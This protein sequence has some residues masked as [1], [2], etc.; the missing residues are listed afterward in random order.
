M[1]KAYASYFGSYLLMNMKTSGNIKNI[2][3]F[4]SVAK[5]EAL[6]ES[7]VDIFI[8]VDKENK[9]LEKEIY[10][11]LENFYKSREALLFKAKNIDNKI[12]LIIG[13]LDE[14]ADLKKSIESTGIILYGRFIPAGVKGRKYALIFWNK[15]EKNRGAFLNKVYGFKVKGKQ[16]K[17]IMENFGGRKLGKSSIMIPIEHRDEFLIISK[18]YGVAA[19]IVEIYA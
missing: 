3:L 17:G 5:N 12:N 10:E 2:I 8:D 13:K 1:L 6:K 4:G 16:Y 14:W 15:I 9:K 18:K 19:K 7:D 11:V